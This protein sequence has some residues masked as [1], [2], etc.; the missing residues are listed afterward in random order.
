MRID[1]YC[2]REKNRLEQVKWKIKGDRY[3]IE[4][5]KRLKEEKM[6]SKKSGNRRK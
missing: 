5:I 3:K 4:N 6:E 2:R 1:G